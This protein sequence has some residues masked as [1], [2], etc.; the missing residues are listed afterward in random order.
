MLI[1]NYEAL[2][3]NNLTDTIKRISSMIDTRNAHA[4][5]M[6]NAETIRRITSM[7]DTKDTYTMLMK[8]AETIRRIASMFDTK[9]TH[10]MLIKHAETIRHTLSMFDTKEAHATLM[11][12]IAET[13][14]NLASVSVF[15]MYEDIDVM[16]MVEELQSSIESGKS[17]NE[18]RK[19]KRQN[20]SNVLNRLSEGCSVLE[21]NLDKG[22]NPNQHKK[23]TKL[24]DVEHAEVTSVIET[25]FTQPKGW[26]D[27]VKVVFESWKD[28][29][30]VVYNMVKYVIITMNIIL[31]GIVIAV[32][33]DFLIARR[34]VCLRSEASPNSEIITTIPKDSIVIATE[35]NRYWYDIEYTEHST[36]NV[37]YGRAAKR[38]F[39][40]YE[41]E[42]EKDDVNEY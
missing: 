6:K 30:F 34:E 1:N 38:N 7:F 33:S 13:F 11:N 18:V 35:Y 9:E 14:K 17:L 25:V 36:R 16:P 22:I 19:S 40:K 2:L 24:T 41:E 10:A 39:A 42:Q 21:E 3:R 8:N 20:F 23:A 15:D 5:L 31:V 32:T 12:N 28:R 37:Y 4:V 29:N 27:I 26:Q